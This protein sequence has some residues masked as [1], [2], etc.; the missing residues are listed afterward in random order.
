MNNLRKTTCFAV[1]LSAMLLF[2]AQAAASEPLLALVTERH[3]SGDQFWWSAGDTPQWT[4][5]DQALRTALDRTGVGFHAVESAGSLSKIYRTAQL[6]DANAI[7]VASVFGATRVLVGTISYTAASF[8]PLGNAGWSAEVSLR[9]LE[10]GDGGAVVLKELA[11]RRARWAATP[12]EALTALRDE[13]ATSV[14]GGA[15]LGMVRKVGPVGVPSDEPFVA[16][17]APSSRAAVDALRNKLQQL[18]GVETVVERWA[19]EGVL[20]LEV[21]PGKADS[22]EAI[23]GYIN[24]AISEGASQFRVLP[25]STTISDVIAVRLEEASP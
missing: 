13:V 8:E 7:A 19:T 5:T 1:V 10:R 24:I 17:I 12:D 14:A 6:S 11:F 16:V 9:L 4:T 18:A 25:T 21:N 2:A 22:R 23:M 20:A 3:A 15:V